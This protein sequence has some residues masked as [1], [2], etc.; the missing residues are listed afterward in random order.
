M[1]RSSAIQDHRRAGPAVD[2]EV[3]QYLLEAA[4]VAVVP[5]SAFGL[6]GY[7]RISFATSTALLEQACARIRTACEQL[8][9]AQRW[10]LRG[11]FQSNGERR[12]EHCYRCGPNTLQVFTAC[13]VMCLQ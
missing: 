2:V 12:G 5:G 10:V 9:L 8:A 11:R 13:R 4:Q 7:F 6:E 3:C 1:R